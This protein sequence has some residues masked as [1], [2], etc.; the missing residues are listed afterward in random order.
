MWADRS[1]IWGHCRELQQNQ[2]AIVKTSRTVR[3]CSSCERQLLSR[4]DC[5]WQETQILL[6]LLYLK[7][8]M[9]DCQDLKRE[10]QGDLYLNKRAHIKVPSPKSMMYNI[11]FLK[12][13]MEPDQSILS[14]FSIDCVGNERHAN[15]PK[16]KPKCLDRHLVAGIGD[17]SQV[18][19]VNRWDK[20]K[21]NWFC[22]FGFN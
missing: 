1:G 11:L 18:P 15:S 6:F 17:K 2:G 22:L 21:L 20:L 8:Q 10:T 16:V 7:V 14:L 12:V 4:T 13:W 19:H 5:D 3:L 9:L